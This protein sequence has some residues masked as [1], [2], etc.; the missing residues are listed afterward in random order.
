[1]VKPTSTSDEIVREIAHAAKQTAEN[2]RARNAWNYDRLEEA[3]NT[4]VASAFDDFHDLLL[5]L[6]DK[7]T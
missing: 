7:E 2:A 5:L 6:V 4:A 3:A 1:M